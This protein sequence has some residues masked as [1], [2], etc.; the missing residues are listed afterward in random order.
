MKKTKNTKAPLFE[1]EEIRIVKKINW[2]NIPTGTKFTGTIKGEE[3]SGRIRKE[4]RKIFLCQDVQQGGTP[5][6]E[7]TLEYP[8]SWTVLYGSDPELKEHEV[9]IRSLELD[10]DFHFKDTESIAL[11]EE[12][13][14]IIRKGFVKVGCQTISNEVIREVAAKLID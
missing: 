10:P 4:D 13:T 7:N 12:Y 6:D 14:A 9:V 8:Y 11:N 2:D 5:D 3:V 1:L